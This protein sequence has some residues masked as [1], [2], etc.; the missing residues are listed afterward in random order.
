MSFST[1]FLRR[2]SRIAMLAMLLHAFAPFAHAMSRV[3]GGAPFDPLSSICTTA[4]PGLSLAQPV[5]SDAAPASP[6]V[7]LVRH[8]P[9]CLAGAHVA[10]A[11][12]P[13]LLFSADTALQHVRV[14]VLPVSPPATAR[15]LAPAPRGPPAA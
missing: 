4:G 14:A 8:C 5:A 6:A 12:L 11:S 2:V 3:G 9:L 10:L 1:A 7:D 15:W 13:A